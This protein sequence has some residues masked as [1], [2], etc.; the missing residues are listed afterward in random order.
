MIVNLMFS[1]KG[2]YCGTELVEASFL[3]KSTSANMSFSNI[4]KQGKLRGSLDGLTYQVLFLR[5]FF[6]FKKY[7]WLV[8]MSASVSKKTFHYCLTERLTSHEVSAKHIRITSLT[9]MSTHEVVYANKAKVSER[10][11]VCP[12]P[13]VYIRWLKQGSVSWW[14]IDT[15]KVQ[16]GCQLQGYGFCTTNCRTKEKVRLGEVQG[17]YS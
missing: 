2:N 3:S 9:A 4:S 17:P 13:S 1:L 16:C 6:T 8:S 7:Y 14:D 12:P 15:A 5:I 11:T 10:N